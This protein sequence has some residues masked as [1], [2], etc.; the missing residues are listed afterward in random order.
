MLGESWWWVVRAV[1]MRR[2]IR[3]KIKTD[4]K[5]MNPTPQHP[6]MGGVAGKDGQGD[7]ERIRNRPDVLGR[8]AVADNAAAA[9]QAAGGTDPW[10]RSGSFREMEGDSSSKSRSR[11]DLGTAIGSGKK[12]E[13]RS[14]TA[15]GMN[16]SYEDAAS[17]A[18]AA[19]EE[20]SVGFGTQA[21]RDI[22]C[23]LGV[24]W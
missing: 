3:R 10:S 2:T 13:G 1:V 20:G 14:K 8:N 5:L 12:R 18:A 22:L 21:H 17:S 6:G 16:L 19:G 7:D 24:G 9:V 4:S 15:R 23:E 11:S